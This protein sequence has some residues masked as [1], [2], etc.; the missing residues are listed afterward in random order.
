MH[1]CIGPCPTSS[2]A[3]LMCYNLS[4]AATVQPHLKLSLTVG[5]V[6]ARD[7]MSSA[8]D[9]HGDACFLLFPTQADADASDARATPC[10]S[11][12]YDDG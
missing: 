12:H 2:F 10:V 9:A 7:L 5:N 6:L 3:L 1:L 11:I 4:I 8:T